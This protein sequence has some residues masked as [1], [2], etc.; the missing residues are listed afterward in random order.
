LADNAA[1]LSC[2]STLMDFSYNLW[3]ARS[4]TIAAFLLLL[5][6]LPPPLQTGKSNKLLTT[7]KKNAKGDSVRQFMIVKSEK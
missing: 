1:V 2:Q 6:F 3:K 5:E 4:A 7:R